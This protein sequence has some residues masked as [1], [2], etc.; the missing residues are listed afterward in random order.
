[1]QVLSGCQFPGHDTQLRTYL[2]PDFRPYRVAIYGA[3][4]RSATAGAAVICEPTSACKH[5]DFRQL[6]TAMGRYGN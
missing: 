4:M 2:W 5:A 1:L 3:W 6:W